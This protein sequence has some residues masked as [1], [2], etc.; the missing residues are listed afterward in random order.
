MFEPCYLLQCLV[1]SKFSKVN[2]LSLTVY[3]VHLLYLM[4]SEAPLCM[5]EGKP[6]CP[7]VQKPTFHMEK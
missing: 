6:G 3:S 4:Y 1:E 5:G 7:A 2:C